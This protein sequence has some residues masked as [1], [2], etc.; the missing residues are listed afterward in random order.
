MLDKVSIFSATELS[1][2]SD[3]QDLLAV[4]SNDSSFSLLA[5]NEGSIQLILFVPMSDVSYSLLVND[6]LARN[7]F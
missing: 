5:M 3:L 4:W 7:N 6:F 1:L 2:P